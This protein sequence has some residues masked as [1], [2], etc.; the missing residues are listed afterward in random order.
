MHKIIHILGLTLSMT[1]LAQVSHAAAIKDTKQ[2]FQSAIVADK[3]T[4]IEKALSQQKRGD[5]KLVSDK[6]QIKVLTFENIEFNLSNFLK[7]KVF[8][9]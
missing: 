5:N 7:Y 2:P 8:V 4:P 3:L 1:L 6:D 9:S